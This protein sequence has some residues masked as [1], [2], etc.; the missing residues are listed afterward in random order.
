MHGVEVP[1]LTPE[2]QRRAARYVPPAA[3]WILLAV[4]RIHELCQNNYNGRDGVPGSTNGEEWLWGKGRDYS[5]AQG[6]LW[7][8]RFGEIAT[9]Q[10]LMGGVRDIAARAASEIGRMEEPKLVIT[11]G[12]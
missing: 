5:S 6:A 10:G 4:E 11:A 2:Q 8:Q 12:R 9:T 7:K 1:R 3:T